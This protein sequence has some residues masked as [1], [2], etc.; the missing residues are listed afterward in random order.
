FGAFTLSGCYKDDISALNEMDEHLQ[1]QI[2][3]LNEEIKGL[4]EQ[5]ASLRSEMDEKNAAIKAEY[6]AKIKEI[7]DEIDSINTQIEALTTQF[8]NDKE[9]ITNDYNSKISNLKDY[10]D[11]KVE[12]L[13]SRIAQD[14]AAL[15]ALETKHNSDK[16]SLE[17]DYNSKLNALSVTINDSIS[18]IQND[19]NDKIAALDEKL[20]SDKQDLI[21]DYTAKIAALAETDS[22]AREALQSEFNTKLTTLETKHNN[23]KAAIESDYNSKISAL[24]QKLIND[25]KEIQDDYTAKLNA[26]DENYAAAV[27]NLQAQITANKQ[28]IDAFK[29]QYLS[30]KEALELDYNTKISNLRTDYENKVLELENAI[31]QKGNDI[32]A[33]EEEMNEALRDL[34]NDYNAKINAL[35][36]RVSTLEAKTYHTVTFDTKDG[37]YIEPV[38]V[39]HG[40]KV[41]KP[42]TPSKTGYTFDKWTYEGEPWVFFGYVV[43]EDITL[44]ANWDVE[45]YL[46]EYDFAG[47]TTVDNPGVYSIESNFTLLSP[48]KTGYTF[49]GWFDE[50]NSQVTAIEPGRTGDLELTAHWND[51]NTYTLTLDANGGTLAETTMSVQYNHS[52]SLPTPSRDDATFEGWYYE[53]NLVDNTGTWLVDGNL[54]FTA[55]WSFLEPTMVNATMEEVWNDI[56]GNGKLLFYVENVM[57]YSFCDRDQNA[58]SSADEHGYAFLG[59][60]GEYFAWGL[61]ADASALSW[62]D[63]SGVYNYTNPHD[64]TTNDDTKDLYAGMY[65]DL[66]II[67][68]DYNGTKEINAVIVSSHVGIIYKEFTLTASSLLGYV[69]TNVAYHASSSD[70]NILGATFA[71]AELGA[72][73]DGIQMRIKDT[74][75]SSIWNTTA[76]TS[77]IKK[78]E[79]T[80]NTNKTVYDNTDVWEFKFGSDNTVSDETLTLSTYANQHDGYTIIPSDGMRYFQMSKILANYTFYVDSIVITLK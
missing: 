41:N 70:V 69:D 5:I 66:L 11:G 53:D 21:D 76:F 68:A 65:L 40:E 57:L 55:K 18:E 14:E 58:T 30:E 79:I 26:L 9:T 48:S 51:G 39:E 7:E 29:S 71:Y 67:R 49:L 25:K 1:E 6:D 34:E 33:L 59:D 56:N 43:T 10:V 75:Y 42:I 74:K 37:S 80:L 38:L 64:F 19:Y 77:D 32:T 47:G 31:A 62:N 60:S 12:T 27:L 15:E 46:I 22:E 52:Y 20:E 50:Q 63:E 17:A 54:T 36:A 16:A 61:T 8:N 72:Y 28:S 3:A 73:G 23:D 45:Y 24:N 4:K 13:L 44:T 2:D 35:T 78:I